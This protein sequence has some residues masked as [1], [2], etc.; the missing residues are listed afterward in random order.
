MMRGGGEHRVSKG[1]GEKRRIVLQSRIKAKGK[2]VEKGGL[3]YEMEKER[4]GKE[5]E[6]EGISKKMHGEKRR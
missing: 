2:E 1:G 3:R 4:K 5:A 6:K